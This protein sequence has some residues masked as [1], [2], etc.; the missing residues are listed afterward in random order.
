MKKNLL[1]KMLAVLIVLITSVSQMWGAPGARYY[2]TGDPKGDW[3]K[4]DD[5]K[6]KTRYE[7]DGKY[8]FYIY[9]AKDNYFRLKKDDN[10]MERTT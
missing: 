10:S 7:K 9:A 4:S 8:V 6:I 3:N 1:F 2:L 5:Y